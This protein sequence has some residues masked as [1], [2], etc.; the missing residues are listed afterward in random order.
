MHG[1]LNN[2]LGDRSLA[3]TGTP[4]IRVSAAVAHH[5][6]IAL[7]GEGE[8]AVGDLICDVAG[9]IAFPLAF[10]LGDSAKECSSNNSKTR[11]GGRFVLLQDSLCAWIRA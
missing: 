7:S 5:L 2:N 4:G 10:G 1:A 6:A 9:I 11:G 8:D 3:V